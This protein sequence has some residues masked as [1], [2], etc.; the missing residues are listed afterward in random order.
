M[1]DRSPQEKKMRSAEGSQER[2]QGRNSGPQRVSPELAEFLHMLDTLEQRF[3]TQS[4]ES[5]ET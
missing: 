2:F 1:V 5:P 3:A 4:D